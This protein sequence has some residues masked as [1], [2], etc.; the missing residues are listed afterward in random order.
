MYGVNY[1]D[2]YAPTV[3]WISIMCL[4]TNAQ[5]LKLNT[6]AIGFTLVFLQDDLEVPVYMEFPAGKDLASRGGSSNQYVLRLIKSLHG[7]KNASL[8][9]QNMLKTAW[10]DR[11]FVGS[12]SDPCVYITKDLNVLAYVDDCILISKE[13]SVITNFVHSLHSGPEN[14]VF[15]EEGSLDS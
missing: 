7:L 8:N 15:I 4:L 13:V 3:N 9:W 11:S 14:F 6:R 1:W 10:L 12:V 2:K 5:V